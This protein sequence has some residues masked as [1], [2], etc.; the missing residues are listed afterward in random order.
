MYEV[1]L[2]IPVYNVANYIRNSLLSAL[3]QTFESIEYIVVDDC[4]TDDSLEIVKSILF[5]HQRA[6][7]VFIYRHN[8]NKGLSAARNTGLEKAHGKF[9]YFMD[10]DDEITEDCIEKLYHTIRNSGADWVMGNI[11]LQG[12]SSQH[13]KKVLE[14]QIEG[15]EIFLSYL[16]QEWLEAACNK[17][18]RRTFLIENELT[19]VS[20][21]LHEDVLWSYHLAKVSK[22]VKFIQNKGYIY[23]VRE[24]SIT[25]TKVKKRVESFA[26][27][28]SKLYPDYS[29]T[30]FKKEFSAFFSS[31]QF[32]A[33]LLIISSAVPGMEKKVLYDSINAWAMPRVG[34]KSRL[35]GLPF[36]VF[37][38]LLAL[39]YKMYKKLR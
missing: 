27:I 2:I 17:L 11:E 36:G 5:S 7:D 3:A 34:L 1:T 16:N 9:V 8:C 13:I 21:L 23:K 33:S 4:G 29:V 20:G 35:L 12:V 37:Q 31:L 39:P 10:S 38:L 24:G 14:R 15:E 22:K 28:L 18:L 6:K 25:S 32:V 30:P 19:F 26:F